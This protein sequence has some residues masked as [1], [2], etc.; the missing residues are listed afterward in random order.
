MSDVKE[1]SALKYPADSL[2]K[3]PAHSYTGAKRKASEDPSS[4]AASK[5]LKHDDSAEPQEEEKKQELKPI[6]FP[7]KVRMAP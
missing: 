1:E 6:P 3:L 5:R 4:P 2:E 7:D